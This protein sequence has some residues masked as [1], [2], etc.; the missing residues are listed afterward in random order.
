MS[1][2][3]RKKFSIFLILGF[4]MVFVL[5]FFASALEIN[6]PEILGFKPKIGIGLEDYVK[7]IFNFSIIASGLIAL[8]S[9]IWGG[10]LYLYSA[11]DPSKLKEAKEQVSGAV[12]GLT[13]LLSSYLL[14]STI[15]P[16]LL[17]LKLPEII[18]V[19]APEKTA[20]PLPFNPDKSTLIS[21]AMPIGQAMMSASVWGKEEIKNLE[22]T[23]ADFENFLRKEE[24]MNDSELANDVFKGIANLNKYL[25]TV[26]DRCHCENLQAFCAKPEN[27]AGA[28]GCSGD[29]CVENKD[30]GSLVPKSGSPRA[31]MNNVLAIDREKIKALLDFQKKIIEQRDLLKEN[32][33]KY[34][35][36]EGLAISC[37]DQG[38]GIT[39]LNDYLAEKQALEEE[40][41]Q[42]IEINNYFPSKG[43]P[44]TFYCPV[45]GTIFDE[46]YTSEAEM[47]QIEQQAEEMA[48]ENESI[49]SEQIQCPVKL[50][51]GEVLDQLR[52]KA[53]ISIVKLDRIS[54]LIEQM[55]KQ[56]QE[57]T[58]L[59]S[60]CNKEE[61]DISCGCFPNPC[62]GC[63]SPVP[64]SICVPFCLSPCLQSVGGCH[65]NAC[66]TE[67]ITAQ[68]ELIKKT[69]D[70]IFESITT[71]KEKIPKD[72]LNNLNNLGVSLGLCHSSDIYNP[73]WS[74]LSCQ[75]MQGNYGP[76]GQ[77]V[78]N[79][80]PRDF[81]CCASS[82]LALSQSPISTTESE[83]IYIIQEEKLP[84]LVSEDNCPKGWLC[85]R[86]VKYYNQYKDASEP[87][88]QLISCMRNQLDIFQ[89]KEGLKE[90]VGRISAIS[91]SK[92]YQGTCDWEMG[93]KQPGGCSHAFETKHGRDMIS[94][95]YGGLNC[96]Y[97]HKSYAIDIDVSDDLQKKYIEKIIEAAK[98]CQPGAYIL[99]E[100][101]NIHIDA[102]E[103]NRC[104]SG[105]F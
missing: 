19:P 55:A 14:L 49:E 83:P 3:T 23:L 89:Q 69:E 56:I 7:Y 94:S 48:A 57:M 79:C 61:C 81:Y 5:P 82:E 15:N 8:A 93:P 2:E 98:Q 88:L 90:I 95:H 25:K 53:I 87:L 66:P 92:I 44:L 35:Q 54:L 62:L 91:D 52:E 37:Q 12:I 70:K 103:A 71:I 51:I 63:C 86:D 68:S 4:L 24:K 41:S 34:Q 29:P 72:D 84:V 11:G 65:G 39:T 67:K 74:L 33:R 26:T 75:E 18:P 40:G 32:L 17:I 96:R 64:C 101:N 76:S 10:I 45:G 9:L 20:T 99:D 43:D 104:V 36:I 46:P 105:E 22:T 78:T 102:G 1:G 42:S 47:G 50:P 16:E 59:A 28:V 6:Y 13:I 77:I 80:H 31:K 60:Q 100:T 73:T 58:E 21:E 27:G 85:S 97:E 30:Q 38:S